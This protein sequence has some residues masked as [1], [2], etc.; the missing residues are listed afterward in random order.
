MC[1]RDSIK[2]EGDFTEGRAG[3]LPFFEP[4]EP[5]GQGAA[6][7][8]LHDDVVDV[9]LDAKI[10]DTDDV[11]VFEVGGSLRLADEARLNV[12]GG[13][14]EINNFDG[15]FALEGVVVGAVDSTHPAGPEQVAQRVF[16]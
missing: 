8:V 16:A 6:G 3:A 4:L 11:A 15:N 7:Q 12:G 5:F 1:I 2:D 13:C 10:V 9:T 14:P